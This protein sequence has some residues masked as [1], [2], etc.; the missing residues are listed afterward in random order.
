M[1]MQKWEPFNELRKLEN[2]MSNLWGRWPSPFWMSGNGDEKWSV[3][4]DVREDGDML[5]VEASIPGMKPEEIEVEIEDGTLTIKGETKTEF[6]EKKKDYLLKERSEGSFYRSIRLPDTVDEEGATSSYK[7]GVLKV[8]M[9]KKA[10]A[11]SKKKITVG[12]Q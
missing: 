3:P 12:V 5:V 10:E 4:L 2:R 1:T 9:P 7:D 6:E 8:T 11:K